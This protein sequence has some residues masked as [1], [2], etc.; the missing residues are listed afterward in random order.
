METRKSFGMA[1]M[2]PAAALETDAAVHSTNAPSL[3]WTRP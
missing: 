3:F 2:A 1:G